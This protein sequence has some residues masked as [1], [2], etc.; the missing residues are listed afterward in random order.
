LSEQEGPKRPLLVNLLAKPKKYRVEYKK[1]AIKEIAK[2]RT[3][4][5]RGGGKGESQ[6]RR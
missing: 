1:R 6:F 3:E 2:N 4:K 5:E